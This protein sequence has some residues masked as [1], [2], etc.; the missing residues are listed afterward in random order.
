M[1]ASFLLIAFCSQI[2]LIAAFAESGAYERAWF[3]SC[4]ELDAA[5]VTPAIARTCRGSAPNKRCTLAE[6]LIHINLS[7]DIDKRPLQNVD[8]QDL[9]K[10]VRHSQ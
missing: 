8:T 2:R 1:K 6:F 5:N 9:P 3:W 10:F 7:D 4:Y